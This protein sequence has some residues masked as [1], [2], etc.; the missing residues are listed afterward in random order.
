M[1]AD[2]VVAGLGLTLLNGVTA[3]QHGTA[4]PLGPP[5]RRALLS[6]LALRRRQWVSMPTLLDALYAEDAPLRA[7]K[8]IQTHVSAL[9]AVLEPPRPPGTPP[10]V[11]L[12]GHGGYQLR[13]ADEQLDLG[14]FENLVAEA[15]RARTRR[16]WHQA[17]DHYTRA[18]DLFHGEPLAGVPGPYAERRRIS[19]AERRLVVLEDSLEN[20]IMGGR[21]E[22]VVD[23]LRLAAAEHPLR[24]RLHGLLMQA[25]YAGGRQSEA[26][27][28]YRHTRNLLI[29]QLGVEPS[30]ELRDLHTRILN[31]EKLREPHATT[32]TVSAPTP[33]H[34]SAL[35][36]APPTAVAG[37]A[38]EVPSRE[39]PASEAAPLLQAAPVVVPSAELPGAE[40]GPWCV[41]REDEISTVTALAVRAHSGTGGLVVVSGGAGT[42]KSLLLSE[43]ARRLPA[44]RW[45]SLSAGGD[46]PALVGGLREALG[47][48]PQ[49][50]PCPPADAAARP[51]AD[52]ALRALDAVHAPVLLFVDDIAEAD[53]TSL[54]ALALVGRG[55][56]R[57]P[58]L[59][60]LAASD[61]PLDD[62]GTAWFAALEANAQ[63]VVSLGPL[64]VPAIAALAHRR[65]RAPHPERTSRSEALA[66]LMPLATEVREI[67]GGL[68]VLVAALLADLDPARHRAGITPDLVTDR[69][70]RALGRLLQRHGPAAVR[71]VRA[72]A[73]LADHQPDTETLAA[74]CE[75]S[76]AATRQLCTR[77]ARRGVLASAEPARL[78]HPLFAT[79]LL[80]AC[81]PD[82]RDR[83]SVAAA[84][85]ARMTHR[86]NREVADHLAELSGTQWAPWAVTLVDAANDCLREGAGPQAVHYLEAA[87]RITTPSERADVLLHL[88]QAE[89]QTNPDAAR[90]H[91]QEAL[92]IQRDRSEPPTAV[93]PLAWVMVSQ[94]QAGAAARLIDTVTSEA[95]TVDPW[96]A[97]AIRCA[98]WLVNSLT[99]GPWHALI[100][101]IR[102]TPAAHVAGDPVATALLIC[103]DAANLR[104]TAQ[105]TLARFPTPRTAAEYAELPR[106]LVGLLAML[107]KWADRTALV[108]Q[109]CDQSSDPDFST[110]DL[111]RVQIRVEMALRRG[112]HRKAL[113]EC[114]LLTSVPLDQDVRR[115]LALVSQYARA[116]VGL[117]R[118]DEAERWLDSV[119]HHADT[120]SWPRTTYL[121]ARG[122]LSSA[123]GDAEQAAAHFLEAGRQIA[124][125]GLDNPGHQ[126]WRCS[127]VTE[128]ARLGRH[129]EA[130]AL[131]EEALDFA[132]RWGAPLYV[133]LAWRA[134]AVTSPAHRRVPLL[135]KALAFLERAESP[136]D[137]AATLTDLAE[138]WTAA[139][140]PEHARPLL[141]RARETAEELH[142]ALLLR[143]I[144]AV[145][146]PLTD[147]RGPSPRVSVPSPE[148]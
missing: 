50:G 6:V 49:E 75:Q 95:E 113:A 105:E 67:T 36:L 18:L 125:W 83:I 106:A 138:A 69:F 10:C 128:L 38:S 27:H 42:G 57:R 144:A 141:R 40:G 11:L 122:I 102:A 2:E 3:Q 33:A 32:S 135:E 97:L 34:I 28:T 46:E 74:V 114:R 146:E 80:H 79:A 143:R 119:A 110:V 72:L 88:G 52:W 39:F 30:N 131:A 19:L 9:R 13:I 16:Q 20:A 112:D 85:R 23:R 130:R 142:A 94:G 45:L 121:N 61:V 148:R 136:I 35:T 54:E 90:L 58:V 126:T 76:P 93:V 140:A 133:G 77:L 117:G 134:M 64:D 47:L 107:A 78:P 59:L 51:L 44:A 84:R 14:R 139:G 68:P 89:L 129:Q 82:D 108:E 120:E 92:Q 123:R 104:L 62:P 63:H 87:A 127:A 81:T 56:L 118:L 96:N 137:I 124:L 65:P 17:D 26:L 24:E 1:T 66:A 25:L 7:N 60:V 21:A 12:Y 43:A 145:E 4:V 98:A 48:S 8:V 71:L 111:S 99:P 132:V 115:P 147:E 41:G 29:E 31:G 73:V 15:E 5:Q 22:Q 86:P 103:D 116:L 91:L 37:P 109:L 101:K 70:A 55:L 53:A 100:R